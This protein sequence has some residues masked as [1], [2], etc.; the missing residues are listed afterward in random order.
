[1][2][3]GG[4]GQSHGQAPKEQ[5][6]QQSTSGPAQNTRGIATDA[7]TASTTP[8]GGAS[9][10]IASKAVVTVTYCGPGAFTQKDDYYMYNH[11]PQAKV[12]PVD[13]G[14]TEKAQP[15]VCQSAGP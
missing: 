2:G 8:A 11:V 15:S 1:M 9:R 13:T 4:F 3:K 10:Y 7:A 14:R 5:Q 6:Q 12:A